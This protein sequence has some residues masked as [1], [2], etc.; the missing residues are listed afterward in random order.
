MAKKSAGFL[1][2]RFRNKRLEIFLV[3]PGGP[4][5]AKKDEGAW[6]L[7]KGEYEAGEEPLSVARR[8]FEEE[9]GFAVED[10]VN[11]NAFHE[12]DD[13]K[14]AGGKIIKA[15]AAEGDCDAAAVRSNMFTMQW[16][17]RSGK[18]AQFPEVDR[19]GW[20]QIKQASRKILKGQAG[21]LDQLCA[22]LEYDH[23]DE[24]PAGE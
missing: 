24:A 15:W 3:H 23:A 6:S 8:E 18:Q 10:V 16:P 2:Y 4:F 21:F 1:I 14:Q 13:L 7:P 12:L 20:F 11:Q 17:P 5:W 19:A 9:T 22:L